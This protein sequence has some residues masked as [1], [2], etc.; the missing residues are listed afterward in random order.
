MKPGALG[1][2][3][4]ALTTADPLSLVSSDGRVVHLHIGRYLADASGADH[5]VLDRCIDPVLDVGCG[6]GRIVHALAAE[7]RPALGV[8]I[9]QAAVALAQ[10]RGAAALIRNVFDQVPG[11]GRWPTIVVLDGNIGIGGDVC[12]L[13]RRL[14]AVMA[15][16]GSVIVEV[17]STAVSVDDVLHVRFNRSGTT[18]GPTFPWA[19]VSRDTLTVH[20]SRACLDVV[21]HWVADDRTFVRLVRTTATP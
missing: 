15:P 17:T 5:T 10:Q 6:P 7:G 18:E 3:E 19:V 16:D 2:Y 4:A 1:P 20:A 11:E 12:A 9:A 14:Y 21:D 13:L 8:D